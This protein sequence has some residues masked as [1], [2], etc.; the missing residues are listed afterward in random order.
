MSDD[1]I[2]L[3]EV[4]DIRDKGIGNILG[5]VAVHEIPV[6]QMLFQLVPAPGGMSEEELHIGEGNGGSHDPVPEKVGEL[7]KAGVVDIDIIGVYFPGR[8]L[9]HGELVVMFIGVID[10]LSPVHKI[11]TVSAL[12]FNYTIYPAKCQ[13]FG[14]QRR[15]KSV[16]GTFD[17]L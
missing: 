7:F 8:Y 2:R 14:K 13:S 12:T 5:V 3:R 1:I 10:H 11:T 4:Y 6:V 16:P 9:R 17:L 15:Q